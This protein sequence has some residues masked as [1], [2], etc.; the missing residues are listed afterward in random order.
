[1]TGFVPDFDAVPSVV[2][3]D[4]D[5]S[6]LRA[7]KDCFF[8]ALPPASKPKCWAP[9]RRLARCA[10]RPKRRRAASCDIMP[11]WLPMLSVLLK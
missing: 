1:M 6:S 10:P 9:T 8:S 4:F 11:C 2:V 5:G 3:E 7:F